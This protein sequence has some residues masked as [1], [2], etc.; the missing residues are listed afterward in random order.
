MS[1]TAEIQPEIV[2]PDC[3]TSQLRNF[4]IVGRSIMT[5]REMFEA[6]FTDHTPKTD[7][8]TPAD[9]RAQKEAGE[10]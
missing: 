3:L 6:M 7:T 8:R 4:L 9:V 5:S 10:L 1:I 2:E